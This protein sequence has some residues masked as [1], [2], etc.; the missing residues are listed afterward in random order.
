MRCPKCGHEWK[1]EGRSKGGRLSRRKAGPRCTEHG[2]FLRADGTCGRC[3]RDRTG[4]DNKEQE[5]DRS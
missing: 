2:C 4:S 5:D 1:D 3:E